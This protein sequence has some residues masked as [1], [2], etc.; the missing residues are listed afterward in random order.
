VQIH[1]ILD[2][3]LDM[4]QALDRIMPGFIVPLSTAVIFNIQV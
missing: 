2:D 3:L 1:E 4:G